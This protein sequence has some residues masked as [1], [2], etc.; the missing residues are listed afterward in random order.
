M[1]VELW[2][3]RRR[4]DGDGAGP[5]LACRPPDGLVQPRGEPGEP[6][7][8]GGRDGGPGLAPCC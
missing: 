2:C 6:G 8:R 1:L 4:D 5:G 3:A 7:C